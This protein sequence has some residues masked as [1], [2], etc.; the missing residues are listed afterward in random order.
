MCTENVW[1]RSISF[2]IE[3][4]YTVSQC[5][6]IFNQINSGINI[7]SRPMWKCNCGLNLI[8]ACTALAAIFE[9]RYLPCVFDD[10]NQLLCCIPILLSKSIFCSWQSRSPCALFHKICRLLIRPCALFGGLRHTSLQDFGQLLSDPNTLPSRHS[11]YVTTVRVHSKK[12]QVLDCPA[13][14]PDLF[15]IENQW[16]IMKCIIRQREPGLLSN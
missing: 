5:H 9:P 3:I 8:T 7:L 4:L 14:S 2:S 11:A 1:M 13:S 10:Q 6:Y 16:R 12:V 15:P